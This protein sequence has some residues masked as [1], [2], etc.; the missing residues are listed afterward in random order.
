MLRWQ[1]YLLLLKLDEQL[2]VKPQ[3]ENILNNEETQN[4]DMIEEKEVSL[5]SSPFTNEELLS[6][7]V[8]PSV[9]PV[10]ETPINNETSEQVSSKIESEDREYTPKL[11]SEDEQNS[12]SDQESKETEDQ[13]LFDKENDQD[14]DFE[15]PAFLRRQKF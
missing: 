11:F 13:I 9:E 14:E 7:T 8:A 5:D 6:E 3:E 2:E 1:K 15:I 4:T 12:R 10:L